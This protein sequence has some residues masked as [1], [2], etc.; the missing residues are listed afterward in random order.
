[1]Y[2]DDPGGASATNGS[3]FLDLLARTHRLTRARGRV[4]S[5]AVEQPTLADWTQPIFRA[6]LPRG[7]THYPPRPTGAYLRAVADR[8]D[9][10]AIMTYDSAA[11]TQAL[12][13]R[14]FAWHTERVLKLIGDRVTVFIGVPTYRPLTDWA[15]DLP[16]ALRGVRQGIG[17]LRRPPRRP[18]GVALYAEW[19]TDHHDWVTYWEEWL[20]VAP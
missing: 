12:A 2:P 20:G 10:V 7:R 1:V 9:Q 13:G 14:H 8:V 16:T 19:T 3:S 15:E 18:Y 4:L 5:A 11:P 6:L 17:A